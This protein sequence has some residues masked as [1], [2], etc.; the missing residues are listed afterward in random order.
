MAEKENVAVPKM[1]VAQA[2]RKISDLEKKVQAFKD[3]AWCYLCDKHKTA[4]AFY[5]STDTLSPI[6][7]PPFSSAYLRHNFLNNST[8]SSNDSFM[9]VSVSFSAKPI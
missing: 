4:D 9:S 7:R 2:K 5:K 1:T 8:A 6:Y 3:G